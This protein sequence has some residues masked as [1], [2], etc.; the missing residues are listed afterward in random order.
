M[1]GLRNVSGKLIQNKV[2]SSHT[3]VSIDGNT[4]VRSLVSTR[5]SDKTR[6]GLAAATNYLQLMAPRIELRTGIRVRGVQ[7][8]QFMTNEVIA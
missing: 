3:F 5:E 7:G 4:S 1:L 2:H 8:N 6:G